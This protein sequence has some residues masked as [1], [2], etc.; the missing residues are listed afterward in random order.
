MRPQGQAILKS[1]ILGLVAGGLAACFG[2]SEEGSETFGYVDPNDPQVAAATAEALKHL[3]AFWSKFDSKAPGCSDFTIK[4]E[5]PTDAGKLPEA[6]WVDVLEH[7][8]TGKIVGRLANEP[9]NI[10][11]LHEGDRVE[12]DPSRIVDWSYTRGE[13]TYGHFTTRALFKYMPADARAKLEAWLPP[14]PLEPQLN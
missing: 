4:V 9:V 14:T 1:A 8:S 13:V 2:P 3:P 11:A 7:P 12:V 5:L 6:I 10:A